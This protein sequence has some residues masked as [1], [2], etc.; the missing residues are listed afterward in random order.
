MNIVTLV[1]I[2][3]GIATRYGMDGLEIDSRW[4]ARFSAP[5]QTGPGVHPSYYTRGTGSFLG[6]QRWGCGVDYTPI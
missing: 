1:G 4:G 6:I 5:V 3:V 2:A